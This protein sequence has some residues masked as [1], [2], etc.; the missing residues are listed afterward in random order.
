[1]AER[2]KPPPA[3]PVSN[4]D[5]PATPLLIKL[6]VGGLRETVEDGPSVWAPAMHLGDTDG[7]PG[8]WLQLGPDVT[9]TVIRAVTQR[10][11]NIFYFSLSL[12]LSL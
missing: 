5:V 2:V 11:E 4:R 1:M 3:V 10:M 9:F 6:P 8:S 7:A 12:P